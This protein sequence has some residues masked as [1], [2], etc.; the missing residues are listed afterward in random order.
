MSPLSPKS[1]SVVIS[2]SDITVTSQRPILMTN[3]KGNDEGNSKFIT[4]SDYTIP[5]CPNSNS[6]S[7][8]HTT[9]SP[10]A[11]T[12]SENEKSYPEFLIFTSKP[13]LLDHQ[14]TS[15][16]EMCLSQIVVLLLLSVKG[17]QTLIFIQNLCYLAQLVMEG[18]N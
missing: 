12:L 18:F 6:P 1:L 10:P 5:S 14:S 11:H 13:L 16:I 2:H 15:W 4:L 3:N 9:F 17:K 8:S 7:H